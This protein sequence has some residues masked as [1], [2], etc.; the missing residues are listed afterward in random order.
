M[1]RYFSEL[2]EQ[3]ISRA[4]EST[5]SV[6]SITNIGLRRHLNSLLSRQS[7]QEAA[8]LAQPLFEH[9][10]GWEIAKPTLKDLSGNLLSKAVV[11][12]LDHKDNARYRFDATFHPFKHQLTA[13]EKLLNEKKSIVVTSGTGSGKTECFMVPI[14]E[15]LH[16]ETLQKKAPLEGVRA[17]FLYPL[18]ALINSQRERLDAWTKHFNGDIRY[19]LY[20]GNTEEKSSRK[21]GEQKKHPNEVLSRELMREKP[22]PILVTNGTMLEYIL[23]RQ[24]DSPI[25]EKSRQEGSLRWIILDE[26]H[27]YVGSQAAEL[28]L[29]L[30]RVLQAFGVEAKDVRFVATSAT[31]ADKKTEDKLK[32]YLAELACV[33]ESQIEVI[34]GER[35]VPKIP[36]VAFLPMSLKEIESI[37]PKGTEVQKKIGKSTK[38]IKL[39]EISAERFSALTKSQYACTLRQVITQARQPLT[40]DAINQVVANKLGQKELSQHDLLRW[41]DLLTGTK[42]NEKDDAFLKV[43]AH[44]FQRM[45][46]GL[47]ACIDKNCCH[48]RNTSL[49]E[50]WPFGYVYVDQRQ[51]CECGAPTLELTF[52]QECNEPHLLG[53]DNKGKIAHWDTNIGDEFSL[54]TEE[55]DLDEKNV[56]SD[57]SAMRN[58][59]QIFAS[60]EDKKK[61]FTF[62]NV[63]KD[64]VIGSFDEGYELTLNQNRQKLCCHCG[65]KGKG[66]SIPFRRAMLGAPFYIANVVPTL[67]EYC[68]DFESDDPAIGVNSLPARGRRLITFTDSRQ[69]TARLAI[70]MQQEAERSKL[71]GSVF[72]ALKNKQ[73]T[74]LKSE[75]KLVEGVTADDLLHQAESLRVMGLI[76]ASNELLQRVNALKSGKA[77]TAKV[78][79]SWDEM[80]D[81]LAKNSDFQGS[82]LRYN[83]YISPE[84]FGKNDGSHELATLLLAREFFRRPKRQNNAETQGLI[85]VGYEGLEKVQSCP[86]RW[87][88]KG[89]SLQDWRDF[90]KLCLDFYVRDGNF[91]RV[92]QNTWIKWIGFKFFPRELLNP[93]SEDNEDNRYKKWPQVKNTTSPHRLVKLLMI[94]TEMSIES[95]LD[96]DIINEWLQV[97][98][99][100]LSQKSRI[101]IADNNHFSIDRN[102]LTFSFCEKV[103]V[104]PVTNKLLDTTLKDYTPYLPREWQNSKQYSCEVFDYPQIHEIDGSQFD[105]QDRL[106]HIRLEVIQNEQ[107]KL[108]RSKNLWTDINDRA[109]EG[110]FYYRIAEHSAQQSAKRLGDYETRFKKGEI[111]VLN[112]STTMEMGVDIG[113]IS[114]VVMNNVPPHPANYLQRAGRAGRNKESRAIAYTLCKNNPHDQQ[115]FT[116]P[117]W[118]FTTLIPAPHVAFNSE[119]LVQ[120]HVNSLL[121]SLFLNDQIGKT[122]SEK[123]KLNLSWFY[124]SDVGLSI[125]KQMTAWLKTDAV[126]FDN[127]IINLVK[128]TALEIKRPSQ[129]REKAADLLDNLQSCWRKEYDYLTQELSSTGKSTVYAYRLSKEIQR[130]TDEYLLRELAA[131]AFLPGYGFP[132]DVVNFDNN[133]IQDYLREKKNFKTKAQER[134]DN[135]SRYRDLP[136]RNLAIAIR[137]YAP[138]AEVVLDG[139]VFRSGG[140]SLHW[141]SIYQS[142]AKEAQ[143]FDIAW[144]CNHCGQTGYETDKNTLKEGLICTNI[145]CN[146]PIKLRHQKEVLV[147]AGFVTDFYVN[148]S[149]DVTTQQFIPIEPAWVSVGKAKASPLPNP[150]M[151]YFYSSTNGSVFH[152][153]S[154]L[155]GTGY[156]LCMCCGRADSMTVNQEIP[157]SLLRK[158]GHRPLRATK[159][160]KDAT[161]NVICEG[162]SIIKESVHLGYQCKTDVF[163]LVLMHPIR[164][165]YIEDNII[166]TT[167]AVA[168][169]QALA[170]QLG[171]S[172]DELGYATRPVLI[173]DK[174]VFAIQLYDILSGGAGFASSA[175]ND[176]TNLLSEMVEKLACNQC[177]TACGDCL[178]TSDTRRDVQL[179]DRELALSWLGE[180]FQSFNRLPDTF[181]HIPNAKYEPHSI[182]QTLQFLVQQGAVKVYIWLNDELNEWDLSHPSFSKALIHYQH[183]HEVKISLVLPD[184]ALTQEIEEELIRFQQLG[185]EITRAKKSDPLIAAQLIFA[186]K[187]ITL[188]TD[189]SANRCPNQNWGLAGGTLI[190]SEQIKICHLYPYELPILFDIED[191]LGQCLEISEQLNG[192]LIQF[193]QRFWAYLLNHDKKLNQYISK[194]DI[195]GISYSDRYIQSPSVLLLITEI[196][197]SLCLIKPTIKQVSISTLF[198]NKD[199]QGHKLHHDWQFEEDFEAC[200]KTWIEHQSTIS[201]IFNTEQNRANIPHRRQL[202]LLLATGNQIIIKLD[203]G[204]G[205]WHLFTDNNSSY[206][207]NFNFGAEVKHQLIELQQLEKEL[208]VKNS[209]TWSTDLSYELK[210]NDEIKEQKHIED[211]A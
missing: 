5:L 185:L 132:T 2:V 11:E 143:K 141:H 164:H 209:E 170:A 37:D 12:A 129:L 189:D 22:A 63:G 111:N 211:Y 69:G 167:L 147:P 157:L 188:I 54:Q 16:Q 82:M 168:L 64:S 89:L 59:A 135:V 138:G 195:I 208:M 179:I 66:H 84:V 108:L 31:I 90:L 50:D 30:R 156:A 150:E 184:V 158:D 198:T 102:K 98:W 154:G 144:R 202:T 159:K 174:Q 7:G 55:F 106:N 72:Q 149:N 88:E 181:A 38:A 52:C 117:A 94:A 137:E 145:K 70:R 112:C 71:R 97:A 47:F 104:C 68:S 169:R 162:S 57:A 103:Y 178:L 75:D 33:P 210:I 187:S 200:F 105:Y 24:A 93:L 67:L 190:S 196:I 119:R 76:S 25:I 177:K 8:F 101:L 20:N 81:E 140:V 113:G 148:P 151:G 118:P 85:R 166:A 61:H 74:A 46:N 172:S 6:L 45:T 175:P 123:T 161:G 125:C 165:E 160:D 83:R 1:K 40:L 206:S 136:S 201:P 36:D 205:Y 4:S 133:N 49:G 32:K 21:S 207:V 28:A 107:I 91:W 77:I 18:N 73:L 186:N 44:F 92:E 29:Q 80:T 193:G 39:P 62:I 142:E 203:Q 134:E 176:L 78:V 192:K 191:K 116:D 41:I 155:N 10:F 86:P 15:D 171:I 17:L 122:E 34:G 121:L 153:T 114:A 87:E 42:P 109:V 53:F 183:I 60:K 180:G 65:Y 9:T 13:W 79:M 115:V 182:K 27:T 131:K 51:S 128:G 23:I 3:S 194:E 130:L 96:K 127:F 19:C 139:R 146:H 95:P 48:K 204:V 124:F 35:I 26:A 110:G 100:D 197:K 199:Y 163:E 14:L 152:H 56:S 58:Q 43:R 120:R 99:S 126:K 173:N